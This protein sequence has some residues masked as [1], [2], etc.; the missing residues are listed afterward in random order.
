MG[1]ASIHK[2]R[3]EISYKEKRSIGDHNPQTHALR[4]SLG[5]FPKYLNVN[6]ECQTAPC[7]EAWSGTMVVDS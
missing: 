4:L 1:E 3:S 6:R 2:G 7:L 5:V